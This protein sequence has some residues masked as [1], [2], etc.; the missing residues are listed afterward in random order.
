[1]ATWQ[2]IICRFSNYLFILL[3]LTAK[4]YNLDFSQRE[5]FEAM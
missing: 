3:M 1:M 5:K 4:S 2:K